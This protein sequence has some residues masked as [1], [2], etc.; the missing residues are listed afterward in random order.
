[1]G[2][3]LLH[4]ISLC[5][6]KQLH[7]A[8]ILF[9]TSSLEQS[10]SFSVWPRYLYSST[11]SISWSSMKIFSSVA[12]FVIYFAVACPGG[13]LWVAEAPRTHGPEKKKKREKKRKKEKER[14]EEKEKEEERKKAKP[15]TMKNIWAPYPR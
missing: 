15:V 13:V 14:R 4:K 9:N 7:P 12:T 11:L 1:M 10:F 2:I 8:F 6:P 5:L 3:S